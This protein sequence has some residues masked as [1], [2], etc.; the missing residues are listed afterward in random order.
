MLG[1][2]LR[3]ELEARLSPL[4]GILKRPAAKATE[5][6]EEDLGGKRASEVFEPGGVVAAREVPLYLW[7]AGQRVV[8]LDCTYREELYQGGRHCEGS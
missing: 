7:K 2:L 6:E 1:L 4:G 3:Q 5:V 8:A